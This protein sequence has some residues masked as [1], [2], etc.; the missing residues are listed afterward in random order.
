MGIK[1][2]FLTKTCL[3]FHLE[4]L[5]FPAASFVSKKDP[6]DLFAFL[7]DHCLRRSHGEDHNWKDDLLPLHMQNAQFRR[8]IDL[9]H[10]ERIIVLQPSIRD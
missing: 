9:Q 3:V 6:M 2:S 4:R 8:A 7:L 10:V 1:D 5:V